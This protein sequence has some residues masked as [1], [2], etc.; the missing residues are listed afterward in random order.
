MEIPTALSFDDVL[1]KPQLGILRSRSDANLETK[2]CDDITLKVPIISSNMDTVTE[3]NMA[4]AMAQ[5]G[6][7]GIIHRYCTIEEQVDM[8]TRVKRSENF[9]ITNPYKIKIEDNPTI[10]DVKNLMEKH[11]V[12]SI[13][14]TCENNNLYGIVTNRDLRFQEND[15]E[16]LEQILSEHHKFR[17][18]VFSHTGHDIS[19]Y[20][21]LMREKRIKKLPLIDVKN[22]TLQGLICAKDILSRKEYPD[23]TRDK[24]QRL[25]VGAA[26]GIGDFERAEALIKAGV[27]TLVLD[28]AH[29]HHVSMIEAIKNFK[30]RWPKV[31][32]GAGNVATPNGFFMLADAGADWIKIGVG[33]G[34]ACKTRIVAGAGLPTFQSLLECQYYHKE[35]KTR[36]MR[37]IGMVADGGIKTSGDIAKSIG[38]GADAV[39]IGSLLAGTEESPGQPI[40]KNGKKVKIYRG[41]A[42]FGANWDRGIKDKKDIVPEGI[43]SLVDFKG[44]VGPII[45]QLAGG[46]RS[47][48]SYTGVDNIPDMQK[49][50]DFYRQTGAGLRE[51]KP[52]MTN[53]I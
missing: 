49:S 37:H 26:I 20:I 27:D 28:I 48:M 12:G 22:Y 5:A 10:K 19:H 41:M 33:S 17:P 24:H 18:L 32:L 39:M 45:N 16:S 1:I 7:L 34:F 2:L 51:S 44:P 9:I 3:D 42:G 40:V 15:N 36:K 21:N 43:E 38:A 35:F 11:R 29:G 13:I 31:P 6:G 25:M 14:V 8:V 52:N 30:R 46:L 50:T 47:G 53:Q 23:A 4:I